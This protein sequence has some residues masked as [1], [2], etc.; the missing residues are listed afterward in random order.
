[1]LWMRK[2]RPVIMERARE[3]RRICP[4]PSPREPSMRRGVGMGFSAAGTL[5]GSATCGED[6]IE[7]EF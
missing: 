1:M 4:P 7:W 5:S 2:G 3:V 6:A